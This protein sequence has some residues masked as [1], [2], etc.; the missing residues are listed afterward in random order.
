MT[1]V[2]TNY[3]GGA[4]LQH[5]LID[6]PSW[7][8]LLTADPT[9]TGSLVNEVVGGSYA[10][11][12]AVWSTPGSKST[13]LG[14]L[15]FLNLPACTVTYIA[16]ADALAGGHLLIVH[17]LAAPAVIPDSGELRFPDNA[18]VVTL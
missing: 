3:L 15:R 10:R 11:L 17:Q 18:V 7:I 1:S 16:V 4:T 5:Y 2:M 14:P 9:V 12:P 13:G 8:A 6:S